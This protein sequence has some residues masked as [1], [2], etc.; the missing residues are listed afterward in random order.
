MP[1]NARINRTITHNIDEQKPECWLMAK[2]AERKPAGSPFSFFAYGAV[3]VRYDIMKKVVGG[4]IRQKI[5]E[6]Q[7]T[8]PIA[9]HT[10]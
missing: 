6:S 7:R 1:V 5:E 2:K 10:S 8:L 4:N 3:G 9:R